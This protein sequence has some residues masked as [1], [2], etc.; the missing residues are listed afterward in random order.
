AMGRGLGRVLSASGVPVVTCLA[1]RSARTVRLAAESGVEPLL[2]LAEVVRRADWFISLVPPA[3]AIELAEEVAW[4]LGETGSGLVYADC[5][6]IAPATARRVAGI[7]GA[8]G[9]AFVDVAIL[10]QPPQPGQRPGP[11]T[12]R[13]Y[14]SG[15]MAPD[16][17]QLRDHGIDVR[18][19]EGEGQS[20]SGLKMCYAALLKGLTALST[21][22]LV[23]AE[24]LEL[25]EPL[26]EELGSTQPVLWDVIRRQLPGMPPKA[27]RWV[28]EMEE[29]GKTYAEVG[30]PPGIFEGAASVYEMVAKTPLGREVPEDRKVGKTMEEVVGV[31]ADSLRAARARAGSGAG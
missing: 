25:T 20:A 24:L 30:L 12:P 4:A 18:V 14:A 8:A 21:E 15:G 28:G 9:A 1:G 17:A 29:M 26:R 13:F 16:F 11:G 23:A 7:V 5:N 3:S 10:G 31:L 6:S 22:L 27:Y 2:D 19:L